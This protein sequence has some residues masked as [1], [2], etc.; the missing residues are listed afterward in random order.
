MVLFAFLA[1]VRLNSGSQKE[2]YVS[3]LSKRVYSAHIVHKPLER[4]DRKG[5]AFKGAGCRNMFTE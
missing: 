1:T 5:K 2:S 3:I 4:T